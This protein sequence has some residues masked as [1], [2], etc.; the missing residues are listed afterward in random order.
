MGGR[1]IHSICQRSTKLCVGRGGVGWRDAESATFSTE[2]T[3][4]APLCAKTG[5]PEYLYEKW[6]K[7]LANEKWQ[8]VKW[9]RQ[10]DPI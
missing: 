3:C 5:T 10:R 9:G 6:L 1:S 2:T 4:L 8:E 7:L